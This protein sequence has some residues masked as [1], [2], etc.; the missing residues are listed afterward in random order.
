MISD[1]KP[2]TCG[3]QLLSKSSVYVVMA[4][5]LDSDMSF[6]FLLDLN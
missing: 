2:L 4:V 3:H 5:P 6:V 1:E